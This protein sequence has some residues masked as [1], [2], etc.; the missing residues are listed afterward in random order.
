MSSEE[1]IKKN[2]SYVIR[3]VSTL[4]TGWA[5]VS[6]RNTPLEILLPSHCEEEA[7]RLFI[8]FVHV[9]IDIRKAG[10]ETKID[11]TA[12]IDHSRHPC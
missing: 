4:Q 10:C 1:K 5:C 6:P 7:I 11:K 2:S 3:W 8:D 9:H 12:N